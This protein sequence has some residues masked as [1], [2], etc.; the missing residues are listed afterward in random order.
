MDSDT[1]LNQKVQLDARGVP[2]AQLLEEVQHHTGVRL[3]A[4]EPMAGTFLVCRYTGTAADLMETLAHMFAADRYRY[5]RWVRQGQEGHYRYRLERDQ[6][7][8][9]YIAEMRRQ[10]Q[11]AFVNRMDKLLLD[12]KPSPPNSFFRVVGGLP[13]QQRAAILAGK[14]VSFAAQQL[15]TGGQSPTECLHELLGGSET[16]FGLQTRFTFY[17]GG[18]AS[19]RVL[20]CSAADDPAMPG[21]SIDSCIPVSEFF[22]ETA[23]PKQQ[24]EWISRFGD[25]V[26]KA[27][28]PKHTWEYPQTDG[29]STREVFHTV[30]SQAGI[31]LIADDQGTD[32]LSSLLPRSASLSELLDKLCEPLPP[33]PPSGGESG[34][35]W[36]R[37]HNTYLVRSLNWP[38]EEAMTVPYRWISRWRE[39]EKR[40]GHLQLDD[41]AG[42]ASLQ[43]EQL[44]L[45]SISF[46]QAANIAPFQPPLRWY[47]RAS[48][49]L[50]A[51]LCSP[52]GATAAE[53][54]V[55]YESA[56]ED[57]DLEVQRPPYLAKL[58]Q[59]PA[60]R[61]RVSL[62]SGTIGQAQTTGAPTLGIVFGEWKNGR[63]EE[64]PLA[65][66][67]PL[68]R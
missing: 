21:V 41:V 32:T 59:V 1:Q 66:P 19:Q 28:K 17:V 42:M 54:G 24:E 40:H 35:F 26:P 30:A 58:Q 12:K 4:A 9:D 48:P 60:S 52:T 11:W 14:R 55:T 18:P 44:R 10:R 23:T 57:L 31:N 36:R 64:R 61:L 37:Y 13:R 46:P 6:E 38:E 29:V 50:K 53:L 68:H 47:L 27:A 56:L 62:I 51:K 45:L 7:L 16:Q 34:R 33:R 63:Q 2:L 67:L 65:F 8:T 3:D 5:P 25:L 22:P 39:S 15:V 49:Q 20:C 43:R